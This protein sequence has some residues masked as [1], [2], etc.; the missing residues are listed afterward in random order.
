MTPNQPMGQFQ[1]A[2]LFGLQG[3]PQMY[4]GTVSAKIRARRRA[5]NRAARKARRAN[6]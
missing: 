5:T 3:K 1:A 2:I 4:E 6:R